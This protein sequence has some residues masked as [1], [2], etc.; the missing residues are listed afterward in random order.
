[1]DAPQ[2]GGFEAHH[3]RERGPFLRNLSN[4]LMGQGNEPHYSQNTRN[5]DSGRDDPLLSQ[6]SRSPS[7]P[8]FPVMRLLLV[9]P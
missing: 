6:L 7:Q 2:N 3:I 8:G 9:S 1:M 5:R 4:V